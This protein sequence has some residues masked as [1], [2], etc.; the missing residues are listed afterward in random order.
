MATFELRRLKEPPPLYAAT[1]VLQKCLSDVFSRMHAVGA[2]ALLGAVSA[3][4]EC[5]R[6]ILMELARAWPGVAR[7]RAP[8]KKLDRLLSTPH[9][10][11]ERNALYGAMARCLLN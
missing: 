7:V 11:Q 8:L 2:Q 1:R 9:L 3:L 5:R 4:I 10:H 6:L